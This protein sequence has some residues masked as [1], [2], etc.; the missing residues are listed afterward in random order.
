MEI[1][2]DGNIGNPDDWK[3]EVKCD[4]NDKYD[5]DGCGAVLSI[6]A[7]DLVMMYWYGSHFLHFYTAVR[8]PQCGKY[9][10]VKVPNLVWEKFNTAKNQNKAIFDGFSDEAH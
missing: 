10:E 7:A 3:A 2:K 6:A 5:K 8:C 9:N 1:V 4:K